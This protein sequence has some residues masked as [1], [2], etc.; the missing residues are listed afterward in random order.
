MYQNGNCF[1]KNL[2]EG[3][4]VIYDET[5]QY[6]IY[7]QVKFLDRKTGEPLLPSNP[8]YFFDDLAGIVPLRFSKKGVVRMMRLKHGSALK[9][10]EK[11]HSYEK[12]AYGG[13]GH[14][15][16]FEYGVLRWNGKTFD[17]VLPFGEYDFVQPINPDG[18]ALIMRIDT[19]SLKYFPKCIEYGVACF[20]DR[21]NI[22]IPLGMYPHMLYVTDE[23]MICF[24][25][26]INLNYGS[27]SYGVLDASGEILLSPIHTQSAAILH[28]KG[29][30]SRFLDQPSIDRYIIEHK[31]QPDP[32]L[33]QP[34]PPLPESVPIQPDLSSVLD[35]EGGDPFRSLD[36]SSI[37]KLFAAL[38][39]K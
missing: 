17:T 38:G 18:Y 28:A 8:S 3:L 25:E 39:G 35:D 33:L 22:T 23:N 12:Y 13:Y 27:S 15:N 30:S 6:D 21:M 36:Q 31:K 20:D 7:Q 34:A 19:D 32:A 14:D 37:D 26:N 16:R 5:N 24:A 2:P 10:A 29:N 11:A 9:E 4:D 1:V